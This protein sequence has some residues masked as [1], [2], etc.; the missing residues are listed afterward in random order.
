MK[1]FSS[2]PLIAR[3]SWKNNEQLTAKHNTKRTTLN[4]EWELLKLNPI[5]FSLL[6]CFFF[7]T[8]WWC[9]LFSVRISHC[10]LWICKCDDVHHHGKNNNNNPKIDERKS[11]NPVNNW[12]VS[13][14]WYCLALPLMPFVVIENVIVCIVSKEFEGIIS[15]FFAHFLLCISMICVIW[16]VFN[17]IGNRI[18][19]IPLSSLFC[20]DINCKRLDQYY[21]LNN[22]VFIQCQKE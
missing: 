5:W 22:Y 17:P 8:N 4:E 10:E 18:Q 16:S 1:S 11:L 19:S 21:I 12:M 13:N 20:V 14:V 9:L 2:F 7:G 3:S 6:V 15:Y